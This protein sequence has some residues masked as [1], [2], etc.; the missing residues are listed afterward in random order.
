M[1]AD[2]FLLCLRRFIAR[3]GTPCQIISDNAKQFKSAR[4][5]L[6]KAHQEAILNDK[7]QDYVTDHGIQWSLIVELAPWT[8]GFY[9]GLVGIT[10][11]ASG[12]HLE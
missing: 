12:R 1:S 4:K 7:I 9:E 2:Q 11:R 8:G 3:R 5:V 6:S 10:K